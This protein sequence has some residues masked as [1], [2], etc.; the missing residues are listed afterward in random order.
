[1]IKWLTRD[2]A[3]VPVSQRVIDWARGD[4]QQKACNE[5]G[6]KTKRKGHT[7]SNDWGDHSGGKYALQG[8]G[9]ERQAQISARET[10][11]DKDKFDCVKK[12]NQTN[13]MQ[14]ADAWSAA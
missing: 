5:G 2:H 1:M 6:C 13:A 4:P 9:R 8:R 10:G 11:G 12:K 7:Q 3:F 14:G